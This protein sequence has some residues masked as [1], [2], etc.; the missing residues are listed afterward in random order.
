MSSFLFN[1]ELKWLLRTKRTREHR[2]R[3][4][5]D[6]ELGWEYPSLN[7]QDVRARDNDRCSIML[8]TGA[9][10]EHSQHSR[11][12]VL[13]KNVSFWPNILKLTQHFLFSE[14]SLILPRKVFVCMY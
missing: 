11:S 6:S 9:G 12:I 7:K 4:S 13:T 14:I 10:H 3:R 8:R 5:G 2:G 1:F